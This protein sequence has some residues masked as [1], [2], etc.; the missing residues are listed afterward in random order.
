MLARMTGR[1]RQIIF[2][3]LHA[4]AIAAAATGILGCGGSR[5]RHVPPRRASTTAARNVTGGLRA[6]LIPRCG[7][8]RFAPPLVQ[9]QV[10]KGIE[11][12]Q[13]S[14]HL[15]PRAP[16]ILG[17]SSAITLVEEAPTPGFRGI[18]GGRFVHL[19]GKRVSL[20]PRSAQY[21][22]Y[23]AGWATPRAR[24]IAIDSGTR[25]DTLRQVVRCLP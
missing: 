13:L 20:R 8:E 2:R 11:L 4:G 3:L 5:S 17:Q 19:G 22:A 12:W 9:P 24:Y 10:H 6:P 7:V 14:Y 23:V 16:S 15:P 25:T 21:P 1:E 18:Q